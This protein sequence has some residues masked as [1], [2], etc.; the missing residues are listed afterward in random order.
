[1]ASYR[2]AV[3]YWMAWFQARC[4]G[5][6][7]IPVHKATVML[8]IVDH[9][10]HRTD[11][12]LTHELPDDVDQALVDAGVKGKLGPMALNTLK[13]RLAALA[14]LHRER[15]VDSPTDEPEVRRLWASVRK[16]Y[17]QDGDLPKKKDALVADQLQ[18][19]LATCD[20]SIR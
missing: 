18:R 5:D 8:F 17:A 16:A 11:G 14:R 12:Q 7:P 20:D 15:Q 9:A 19:L 1:M 13:H 3:R 2:T 4:G 6:L 10:Q